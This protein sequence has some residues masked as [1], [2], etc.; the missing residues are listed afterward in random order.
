MS[1]QKSA[2]DAGKVRGLLCWHCNL[3]IGHARDNIN[4]LKRLLE[5]LER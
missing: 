5:Y 1:K 2:P 4:I 3:A